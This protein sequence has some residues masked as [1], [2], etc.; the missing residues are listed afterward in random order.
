MKFSLNDIKVNI[1]NKPKLVTLLLFIFLVFI[2]FLIWIEV[3]R[4]KGYFDL[5]ISKPY[6]IKIGDVTDNDTKLFV[7]LGVCNPNAI[8]IPA[9]V[10][11]RVYFEDFEIGSVG[12]YGDNTIYARNLSTITLALSIE[13][14]KL[15]NFLITYTKN[16]EKGNIT[17]K[18]DI[19][20]V[21]DYDLPVKE[22]IKKV[23]NVTT[24]E[25]IIE[26]R[27]SVLNKIDEYLSN[28]SF[29]KF[30]LTLLKV[31]SA[32]SQW[33]ADHTKNLLLKS[34]ISLSYCR[35]IPVF[36][37]GSIKFD[38][39]IIANFSVDHKYH[40]IHRK[41]IFLHVKTK[42]DK[43]GL[44][45]WWKKFYDKKDSIDLSVKIHWNK[46]FGIE[47]DTITN[48]TF[49]PDFSGAFEVK[50]WTYKKGDLKNVTNYDETISI[51]SV[52]WMF[53]FVFLMAFYIRKRKRE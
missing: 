7:K 10:N 31:K 23:W 12:I 41:N 40:P 8:K 52:L 5:S 6:E 17:V 48:K 3:A 4:E 1:K 20:F 26:I 51:I 9:Y 36:D 19:G 43:N 53:Y 45:G 14:D 11:G 28:I 22:K 29:K 44:L 27:S 34:N 37:S 38:E 50:N 24:Q 15:W 33:F 21:F 25:S 18:A 35:F 13:N 16:G 39:N 49:Q 46:F 2:T 47:Y 32:K 30:G 42:F